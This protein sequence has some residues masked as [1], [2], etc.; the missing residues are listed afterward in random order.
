MVGNWIQSGEIRRIGIALLIIGL[1]GCKARNPE[2]SG[3]KVLEFAIESKVGSLDPI[4]AASSY[5]HWAAAPVYESLFQYNY[6]ARPSRLEPNLLAKMPTI[7]EDGL[8]YRFEL[9]PGTLF[10]DDPCFPGGSGR[11][12]IAEDVIFSIKRMANLKL[13]PKGWWI[14][15]DRIAGFDTYKDRQRNR[16]IGAPF[17][18]DEPVEGLRITGRYTFELKL[19][20]AYPQLLSVL[21]MPYTSVIAREATEAYRDEFHKFAVGTGPF[22]LEKWTPG[23]E[24]VYTRN[25]KYRNELYPGASSAELGDEE[26]GLLKNAGRRLPLL[27]VIVIHVIEASQPRWLKF[28]VGDLDFATVPAE[29][30]DAVFTK[31][32]QIRP[33]FQEQDIGVHKVALLDYIYRGFNMNDPVFGGEKGK[34]L[35]QA[36]AMAIDHNEFNDAFYNNTAVV[37]DG[38]IPPG[39]SGHPDSAI[40]P[41]RGPQIARAKEFLSSAGYPEGKGLPPLEFETSIGGNSKEQADMLARQLSQIGISTK[42][43]FNHFPELG[44]KLHRNKAQFF[45]IAWNSDY[46]DAENNLAMFY[47]PNTGAMNHFHYQNPVYDAL[48][49]RAST[50]VDSPTRTK[51]YEE[52]RDIIIEDVPAV[53]A[54]ARTRMYLWN[55]RLQNM[56]PSGIWYG[57]LKYLDVET[58]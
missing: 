13:R 57:W 7:S 33:N 14:Y 49:R 31:D 38:P 41:Y 22:K 39:L 48:Y 9:K 27:D 55:P 29:F 32:M 42:I 28:R 58:R 8:T 21:A 25:P 44:D 24:L 35:R 56:K 3:K 53:G 26:A 16:P 36:I 18:Y 40:S 15:N 51:L 47:G 23:S 10:H 52:M 50:M 20:R 46:P 4:R 17:N 12:L 6:L 2:Y 30:H 19:K 1:V 43:N 11:E 37:Y 5:D 45:G 54:L 34:P